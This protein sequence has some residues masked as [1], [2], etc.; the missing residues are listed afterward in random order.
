MKN[1]PP[2]QERKAKDIETPREPEENT[3]DK[4]KVIINEPV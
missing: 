1:P 4:K 2:V 3:K